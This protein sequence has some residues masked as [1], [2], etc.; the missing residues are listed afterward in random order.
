[1]AGDFFVAVPE[2]GDL[3][4]LKSVIHNWDDE[5][6]TT[7]LG[8]CRAAMQDHARLLLIERVVPPGNEPAEAKL[9]DINMLV[10]VGGRERTAGAYRALLDDAGLTMTRLIP[11]GSALSLIEARPSV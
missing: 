5:A 10:V 11:T 3:Y 8:R 4:L 1:V 2:G 9:F 7:I 6:A